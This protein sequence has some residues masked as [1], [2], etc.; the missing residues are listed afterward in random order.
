[1]SRSSEITRIQTPTIVIEAARKG[2][3]VLARSLKRL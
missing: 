2:G 3:M 1:M